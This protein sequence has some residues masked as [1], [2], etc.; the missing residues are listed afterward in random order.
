M[1]RL[2]ALAFC[3][4]AFAALIA[5]CGGSEA[6]HPATT[7]ASMGVL[8]GQTPLCTLYAAG[9]PSTV[10]VGKGDHLVTTR[11][12]PKGGATYSFSLPAGRYWVRY[13][14]AQSSVPSYSV[15]VSPAGVAHVPELMCL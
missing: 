8:M 14:L 13:S 2:L 5:G 4:P 3:F 1:R 11:E 7:A 10:Y 12:F 9:H 15:V 6:M